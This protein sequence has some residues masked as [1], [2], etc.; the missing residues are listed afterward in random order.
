M[1]QDLQ[2]SADRFRRDVQQRFE[3]QGVDPMRPLLPPSQ[4]WLT[5][6]ELNQQ[7]KTLPRVQLNNDKLPR[8]AANTNLGYTAL[9]DLKVNPQLKSRLTR[10]AASWKAQ[11]LP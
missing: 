11:T 6:E 9:P 4:L 10:C 7:M 3:S 2:E 1:T 5:P 8:K